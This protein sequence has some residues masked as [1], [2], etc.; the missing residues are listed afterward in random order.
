[1]HFQ[2]CLLPVSFPIGCTCVGAVS[3][4]VS[5]TIVTQ[6][7]TQYLAQQISRCGQCTTQEIWADASSQPAIL[8]A[9]KG[10]VPCPKD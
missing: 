5:F 8:A 4:S 6:H 7:I 2:F 10:E 1:M 9:S 3:M